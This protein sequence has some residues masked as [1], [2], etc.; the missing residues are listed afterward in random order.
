LQRAQLGLLPLAPSYRGQ[1]TQTHPIPIVPRNAAIRMHFSAKIL[2]DATFFETNPT[3][4]QLLEFKGD[5]AVVQP[6]NAFR[7]L[8]YRVVTKDND[9]ILDTTILGGEGAAGSNTRGLPASAD[10]VTANIRIAMPARGAVSPTFYVKE[11]AVAQLN[12]VDTA[13][14]NSVIRDF[15]SGNLA[16][17]VSGRLNEPESP[18]IVAPLGMGITQVDTANS[19]VTLNKRAQFVPIRARY[20]FVDGP[21]DGTSGLPL[22]PLAAPIFPTLPAGDTLVQFIQVLMPNGSFET[23]KLRAEI[24]QNMEVGTVVGDPLQPRL[25]LA[26]NAPPGDSEQGEKIPVIRVRLATLLAG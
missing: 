19:I 14:R 8:P 5:P 1:N 9:V 25:G 7:I 22:G 20:P 2:A 4:I 23:V 18:M 24:L 11:D 17:G 26:E 15:R 21:L 12:G 13:A 3:A 6:V 10:Q 16:D